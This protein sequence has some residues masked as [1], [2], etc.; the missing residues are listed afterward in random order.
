MRVIKFVTVSEALSLHFY[1]PLHII[2]TG[3]TGVSTY[4]KRSI[5]KNVRNGL[6]SEK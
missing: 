2:L 4:W 3:K 5:E 1:H 6:T